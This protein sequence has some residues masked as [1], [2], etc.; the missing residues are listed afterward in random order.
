MNEI[1]YMKAPIEELTHNSYSIIITPFRI[2]PHQGTVKVAKFQ[3]SE[4]ILKLKE[5]DYIN[6][7]LK[8]EVNHSSSTLEFCNLTL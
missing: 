8:M 7:F 3:I 2:N 1:T 5:K 6:C 4:I